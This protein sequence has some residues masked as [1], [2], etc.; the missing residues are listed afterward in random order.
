VAAAFTTFIA[1]AAAYLGGVSRQRYLDEAPP[2]STDGEVLQICR[3]I[4]AAG[5]AMAPEFA[6]AL[7]RHR[8]EV[9]GIFGQRVPQIV[10]AC[11]VPAAV[12]GEVLA[13]GLV[14]EAF[15]NAG[16]HDFRDVLVGLAP[17]YECARRLRLDITDV[18][19]AAALFADDDTATLLRI[20]GRRS[21]VTLP[22]F[23]WREVAT[24]T[25]PTFERE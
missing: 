18:F 7:D 14:A 6:A 11:E 8:R 12:R 3:A 1:E 21:D 2:S 9:L 17:H 15:A 5:S 16:H 24:E 23:G 10:L 19:D 20:F 22:R 13:A 4:E 25:G